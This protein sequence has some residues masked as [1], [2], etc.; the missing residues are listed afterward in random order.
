M[1]NIPDWL[2]IAA[3]LILWPTCAYIYFVKDNNN[4]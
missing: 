2:A 3:I 1:D 4:V